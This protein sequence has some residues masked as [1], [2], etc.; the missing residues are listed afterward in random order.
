MRS[1]ALAAIFFLLT[2]IL[3]K[4]LTL[5]PQYHPYIIVYL[6][7]LA[8]LVFFALRFRS[9]RPYAGYFAVIVLVLLI[10]EILF[11][12]G[13]QDR[14][15]SKQVPTQPEASKVSVKVE[16]TETG[17][18]TGLFGSVT[19]PGFYY[20]DHSILGYGPRKNVFVTATR[21][22]AG[23]TV[24]DVK[25][26]IDGNGLRYMPSLK[27][28]PRKEAVLFFGDSLTFG[29]GHDDDQTF[30]YKFQEHSKKYRAINLGFHGY[31]PHQMLRLLETKL[32]KIPL[33]ES[34]PRYAF[35]LA[36]IPDHYD[37]AAGRSAW[38]LAGPRYDFDSRGELKF[39]GSFNSLTGIKIKRRILNSHFLGW[40]HD[41]ISEKKALTP[42]NMERDRERFVEIVKKSKDILEKRYGTGFYVLIYEHGESPEKVVK[43]FEKANVKTMLLSELEPECFSDITRCELKGD[44]HPNDYANGLLGKRLAAFAD[45]GR[46]P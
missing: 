16:N 21:K 31:G 12:F 24:Y 11:T 8:L 36:I 28:G 40:I 34:T 27:D 39:Y 30:V 43:L 23:L 44:G 29:E 3:T 41:R 19:T 42:V 7:L 26:T 10:Y 22:S 38:D 17:K 5:Y 46:E 15:L 9:F 2:A 14:F 20:V 33:G 45:A 25:Y 37:R 4:Y 32:E 6:C 13:F 35:Y 1:K 18:E